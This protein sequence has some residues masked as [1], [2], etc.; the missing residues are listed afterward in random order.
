M[1]GTL[2]VPH[3]DVTQTGRA[4]ERVVERQD[5]TARQPE[6]VLDPDP[7]QRRDEGLRP[8]ARRAAGGLRGGGGGGDRAHLVASCSVHVHAWVGRA[9]KNPS[10][11]GG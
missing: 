7:L 5:R 11:L 2:L 1:P 4:V 10:A 6:D 3:Q 9:S 8:G